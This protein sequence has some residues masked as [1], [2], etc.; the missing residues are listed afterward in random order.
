MIRFPNLAS[1]FRRC[2]GPRMMTDPKKE[3]IMLSRRAFVTGLAGASALLALKPGWA[4][5]AAGAPRELSFL[6][7]HTGEAME[8]VYW[9]N[10]NYLKDGLRKANYLL[11]DFRNGEEHR[12]DPALLDQLALLQQKLGS[13]G[14]FEIISGYRSPQTN[15]MLRKRGAGVAKKSFHLQGKAIDIRL[16]DVP[17]H[18][19]R[20]AAIDMSKGGV[21]IYTGADFLH[22]DT[23]PQRSWG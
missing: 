4:F 15:K 6:H 7:T 8:L 12:I 13:N 22:L 16:S 20:S 14:R 9:A 10:G 21:G 2:Y 11:R 17:L 19:L 23:G 5:A 18:E 3:P 1:R